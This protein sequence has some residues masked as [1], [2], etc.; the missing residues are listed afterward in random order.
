MKQHGGPTE[1]RRKRSQFRAA[2]VVGNWNLW[3]RIAR[4]SGADV[5]GTSE[6]A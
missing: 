2:E 1:L 3:G 4:G 5:W 6:S